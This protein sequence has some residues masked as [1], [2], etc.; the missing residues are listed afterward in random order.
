MTNYIT[1][2]VVL[3][4]ETN[5][6]VEQVIEDH[7][8]SE[9]RGA[10]QAVRIIIREWLSFKHQRANAASES[11]IDRINEFEMWGPEGRPQFVR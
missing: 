9:K 8:L 5:A 3:D 1:R 6:A 11:E 2:N 7:Y 4:E 10:S